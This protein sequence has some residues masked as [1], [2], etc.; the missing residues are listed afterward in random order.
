M[1]IINISI[2]IK[3]LVLLRLITKGENL[4]DA[5][6]KAGLSIQTAKDYLSIKNISL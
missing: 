1:S 2:K 4:I 5:C 3:Y 6:S